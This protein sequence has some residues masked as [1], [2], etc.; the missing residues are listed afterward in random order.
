MDSLT[1]RWF[2]KRQFANRARGFVKRVWRTPAFPMLELACFGAGALA[3]I[4]GAFG[5]QNLPLAQRAMFWLALMAWNAVKWRLWFAWMVRGHAAWRRASALGAVLLNLPLP[6]E[7][8][9]AL[10]LIGVEAEIGPRLIWLEALAISAIVAA[11]A[12]AV[13][14]LLALRPVPV[15]AADPGPLV[16]AGTRLDQVAAVRAE[17]HYCRVYLADGSS[18]LVLCRFADALRELAGRDGT[19]IHRSAWVAEWAVGR[20]ERAGRA[21]RLVAAGEAFAVSPA[22]LAETRRRGWLNRR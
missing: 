2:D 7:I 5:T 3:V 9:V 19:R 17:D 8:V 13:R 20:A 10:R 11:L 18:R 14:R 21:W 1:L 15:A 22:H 16:R 12:W 6:L 4:S